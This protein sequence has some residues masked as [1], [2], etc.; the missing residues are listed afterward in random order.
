MAMML[1]FDPEV[2]AFSSQLFWLIW[3]RDGELRRHAPDYFARLP[4]ARGW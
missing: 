3:A 1:D 2:V 4:M